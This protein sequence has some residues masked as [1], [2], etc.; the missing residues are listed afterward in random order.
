MSS[1][2]S[3][4][5]AMTMADTLG[6]PSKTEA[7][8]LS[9]SA[10][11]SATASALAE[12]LMLSLMGRDGDNNNNNNS[13][14]ATEN[15]SRSKGGASSSQKRLGSRYQ[16]TRSD[17]FDSVG[18]SFSRQSSLAHHHRHRMNK[19]APRYPIPLPKSIL[20]SSLSSSKAEES[21]SSFLGK[22]ELD[23]DSTG[24]DVALAC[25]ESILSSLEKVASGGSRASQ[26]MRNLEQERVRLD[27]E[28]R[29]I[30][31][32]LAYRRLTSEASDALALGRLADAARSVRECRDL[33][34]TDRAQEYAGPH[35]VRAFKRVSDSLR[36]AVMNRFAQAS[37]SGDVAALSDVTPILG[38]LSMADDGVGLYLRYT[39]D[40][41]AKTMDLTEL[42]GL[43]SE[44]K[45][46]AAEEAQGLSISRAERRRREE[47]TKHQP[48]VT[49]CTKLA[50]LFN[51]AVEHLR[52]HL[53]MV[54][55]ALGEADGDAALVQL[56][57]LEAER[58]AVDVVKSYASTKDLSATEAK[59][60][61]VAT[62][63]ENYYSSDPPTS[64]TEDAAAAV[65]GALGGLGLQDDNANADA[66]KK[67]KLRYDDCGFS[68][69]IG[70]PTEAAA[71]AEE[72]ALL[73]QH[74][75]SYERFIRHAVDEVLKART[76][77]FQQ[78]KDEEKRKASLLPGSDTMRTSIIKSSDTNNPNKDSEGPPPIQVLPQHTQLNEVVAEVGGYYSAIERCLLLAGIQRA[79][80]TASAAAS[81]TNDDAAAAIMGGRALY[82]PLSVLPEGHPDGSAGHRA[83][84][85]SLV[86]DCLFAAQR[87]ALRAIA[88]GHAMTASAAANFCSDAIGRV[89]VSIL[90]RRADVAAVA[91]RPAGDS[92]LNMLASASS[93]HG[94]LMAVVRDTARTA[95]KR[96]LKTPTAA[97][98]AVAAV[99]SSSKNRD[100]T[101]SSAMSTYDDAALIRRRVE[102][103]VARTCAVINDLEVASNYVTKFEQRLQ[104]EVSRGFSTHNPETEQLR[105]CIRSIGTTSDALRAEADRATAALSSVI[106]PRVRSIVDGAVGQDSTTGSS[107]MGS[108]AGAGGSNSAG[109]GSVRM[110]YDLDDDTYELLLAT[111]GYIGRLCTNLD[112]L[113]EPLRVHLAP[114]LSDALILSILGGASKRM[115][116]AIK[117]TQ[118][119]AVGALALDSDIRAFVNY[120]KSRLDG[121]EFASTASLHRLCTPLARLSQIALLLNVDD[122]DDV[123]DLISSSK[124]KNQWDLKL[125]DA[126]SL[127]SLRVDFEG[128]KVNELLNFA[129][130]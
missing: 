23:E 62:R 106:M 21:K 65:V 50:C 18:S 123:L 108:S 119:T 44:Q 13:N 118:F 89:M 71:N 48:P 10:S 92:V 22:K 49:V 98:A 126:K 128:H 56:V 101:S 3:S 1:S 91:L 53:P 51:A 38:T 75:E 95:G 90:V 114:R 16:R 4:I 66:S 73:L 70:T 46:M 26:E 96:H 79:S 64:T 2:N 130:D 113:L 19:D 68:S 127:L 9:L 80:E 99:S 94:G 17:S 116:S 35:T 7:S 6:N 103:V 81:A 40:A 109:A 129:D 110:N 31:V 115:E 57:H 102:L 43:E 121:P 120:V 8:L 105:L 28:A 100:S 24:I 82:L 39:K 27:T 59:A 52:H 78:A 124:R 112:E 125:D 74:A 111:E 34:P 97:A 42:D 20:S 25:S 86:E 67:K 58:R 93:S 11:S 63:I 69:Q 60:E 104:G 5:N 61:A 83:L 45:R 15:V 107:F 122:L 88:T 29:D 33:E 77:R 76:L 72:L 55:Y 14:A 84:Q 30:S 87:S 36:R 32:A 47:R 54:T 117:R 41:L 12:E 85:T 37:S